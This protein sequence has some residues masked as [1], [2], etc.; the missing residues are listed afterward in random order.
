MGVTG[1]HAEYG[2]TTGDPEE[3]AMKRAL[4]KLAA[5]T[6]VLA[7]REKLGAVSPCLV[8]PLPEIDMLLVEG[9]LP[10]DLEA[11]LRELEIVVVRV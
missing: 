5:E 10:F 2:L 3:A 1:V 7:S 6:I 8:A 11:R 4:C 9:E